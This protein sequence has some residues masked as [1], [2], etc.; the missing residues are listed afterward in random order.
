MTEFPKLADAYAV[1]PPMKTN[2]HKKP[3]HN[4]SAEIV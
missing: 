3:S 2:E 4:F 1:S